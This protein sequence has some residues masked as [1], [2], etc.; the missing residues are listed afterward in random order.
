MKTSMTKLSTIIG[1][2]TLV[3]ASASTQAQDL[4]LTLTNLTQ[5]VFLTP[6]ITAAHPADMHSF[7]LGEAASDALTAMAEGG[8]ISGLSTMWTAANADV[9]EN[10]NMGALPPGMSIS[11]DMTTD[12]ANTHLSLN[13]MIIP[14]N[15][16][17]IALDEWEIP[18]EA[19]TYT[20]FLNGYDAGTEANDE[21]IVGMPAAMPGVAGIPGA[22]G[23]DAGTGGTGITDMSN[24]TTVHI[25][26]GTIG[27]D[28]LSGGKSDLDNTI[29]RWLNPVAKLTITVQ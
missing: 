27:D 4:S 21:L 29:H 26:P 6:V 18:T 8:D 12:A 20:V 7:V 5:G 25:H 17:F 9:N 28:N 23:M 2:G 10:P 11:Y 3:L 15:D 14:S 22:P 1:M 24:N 13:T 16:G 19:G